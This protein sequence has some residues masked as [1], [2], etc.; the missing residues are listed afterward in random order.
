MRIKKRYILISVAVFAFLIV[1]V[2]SVGFWFYR[3]RGMVP[4]NFTIIVLP[5]TQFYSRDYPHI[6]NSQTSWILNQKKS[7]NIVFVVHEGDIVQD[8]DS[9]KQWQNANASLSFLD[10]QVPYAVLPGNHDMSSKRE[11][12]YYNKYFPVY[13]Y[14]K[15][16]WYGN[17]Y[18]SGRNDNSY[19]L[20]SAG[21]K[22]YLIINLEF[23]PTSDVLE[24]ADR[25]LKDYAEREAIIVTHGYLGS[26]GERNIHISSG[27]KGGCTASS[28]NTQYL[29]NDLIYPNSNVFLVLSG[30]VHSAK[31]RTDDN[32]AGKPVYQL[33]ANYQQE[34]NGGNGWL[35]IMEFIPKENRIWVRTYSPYLDR[36]K[37]D[38]ENEF[39]LEYDI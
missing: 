4:E 29:W 18:P 20:F 6:F 1:L 26:K 27:K 35:R 30:H 7:R 15:Y 16:D 13:R 19:Q 37:K 21:K 25:I 9:E 38:I 39:S 8:W 10:G 34:D 32:I 23:C 24:W 28:N 17:N 3:Q 2:G 31:R 36:Y 14:D 12:F 33:L 11:T 22:D 5:D